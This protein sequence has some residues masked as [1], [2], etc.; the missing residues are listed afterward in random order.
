MQK[1]NWRRIYQRG[2]QNTDQRRDDGS[3]T[4]RASVTST[5]V[6]VIAGIST[7]TVSR[8][9]THPA[10]LSSPSGITRNVFDTLAYLP[11]YSETLENQP[12]PRSVAAMRD[13]AIEAHAA[14]VLT[15]YH[16]HIPAM[17]HKPSTGSRGGGITAR[18]TTNSWP[19]SVPQATAT[20]RSGCTTKSKEFERIPATLVIEARREGRHEADPN[21]RRETMRKLMQRALIAGASVLAIMSAVDGANLLGQAHANEPQCIANATGPCPPQADPPQPDPPRADPPQLRTVCTGG[22]PKTGG[23]HCFQEIVP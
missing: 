2:E 12:L 9:L 4:R 7:S 13:A 6:L 8:G 20:A 14:T 10:A 21:R 23:G 22:G 11:H 16:G 18:Y 3:C 1:T 5:T 15:H 17:V 19:S